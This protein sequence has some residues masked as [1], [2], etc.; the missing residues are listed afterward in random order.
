MEIFIIKKIQNETYGDYLLPKNK[1]KH[2]FL[3]DYNYVRE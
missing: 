2:P 3:N 1:I